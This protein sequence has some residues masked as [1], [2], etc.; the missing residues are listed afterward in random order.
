[1]P[2]LRAQPGTRFPHAW[3]DHLGQRRST[4]DLFGEGY[5]TLGGAQAPRPATGTAYRV[6]SDFRFIDDGITWQSLTGLADDAAL[7]IRPDG[8][9][10]V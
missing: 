10:N 9:V 2:T 7:S 5:V 6:G 8:I 3:I 1:M 4:L